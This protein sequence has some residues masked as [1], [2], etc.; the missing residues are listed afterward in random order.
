MIALDLP[1][2][3]RWVEAHALARDPASWTRPLGAGLALGN[4]ASRLIVVVGDADPSA[5]TALAAEVAH[6]M[7]IAIER[8][9]LAAATGRAATRARIHTLA[10]PAGLPELEGAVV[11]P[12][13]V[14]LAHLPPPLADEVAA[15]RAAHPVWAVFLD[16]EPMAFAYAPWRSARW[17]DVS[18]DTLAT[19]R[20]LGLAT[21]TA[22]AMIR[23]ERA[24]GREP[25]WGAD[26]GN[27]A[28]LGLA[29]RL[30][31]AAVDEIWVAPP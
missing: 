25:V 29:K 10:D 31:F 22:A 24:A 8:A 30:G 14:S 12:D 9:D 21:I 2:E 4:D 3:P 19:A 26:E 27:V 11:L 15:A 23:H 7:L 6:P 13:D 17:F 5:V 1:D 18:V 16:G 28:S 20:Q